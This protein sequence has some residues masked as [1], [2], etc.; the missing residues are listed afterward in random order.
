MTHK[1]TEERFTIIILSIDD[2]NLQIVYSYCVKK[3]EF[4]IYDIFN[5]QMCPIVTDFRQYLHK[6]IF[7]NIKQMRFVTKID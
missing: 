2:K 3:R 4:Y 7:I 1:N 6:R 5:Y